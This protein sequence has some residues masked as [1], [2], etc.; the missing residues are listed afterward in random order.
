VPTSQ[1]SIQVIKY[2]EIVNYC[3]RKCHY[4]YKRNNQPKANCDTCGNIFTIGDKKRYCSWECYRVGVGYSKPITRDCL[5]CNETFEVPN[6]EPDQ[7]YCCRECYLKRNGDWFEPYNIK[8]KN[9]H[10]INLIKISSGTPISKKFCSVK[11]FSEHNFYENQKK[12]N[13]MKWL[14][15]GLMYMIFQIGLI[16]IY[17]RS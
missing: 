14:N 10:C 9:E 3:S 13:I 6:K 16:L 8:C 11:C 17:L 4:E 7:V 12:K 2:Y 1:K 5:T 15:L